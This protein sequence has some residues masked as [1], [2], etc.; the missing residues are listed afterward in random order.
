[1]NSTLVG[2]RA[3]LGSGLLAASVPFRARAQQ[4][5]SVRIGVLNDQNGP[6][7]DSGGPGSVVAARMAVQD[8]GGT[9]LGKKI[10]I[11]FADTRNKPDIASGVAREW[12]D[13]GLDAITDL[14]V[15]PIAAAV[16][17]IAR[18]RNRTV[19]IAAAVATEFTSKTCSPVSSHWVDDTHSMVSATTKAT[20]KGSSQKWFFI[21]VDYTFGRALQAEATGLIEAAGGKVIG[22]D[23]FPLGSTDFSSQVVKAQSSGADVIGLAAVGNDQVNLIKQAGE[24]GLATSGK[25]TLAGFLIYI[26]DIHALGLALSQGLTFGSGF[27]WDQSEA[28]RA[29]GKRYQ[30]E[31]KAMPSKT[32]AAV[33]AS[34]LHFLKSM[35]QAGTRDAIAVNRAMRSLPVENFGRPTTLRTDGRVMYDLSLYRVKAPANS[36]GSWDYYE[37]IGAIPAGEAF[38][39][40]NPDCER[41]A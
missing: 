12:Y 22:S 38:L 28:S 6:Y 18:E 9:V 34:T 31:R 40:I 21:T 41:A 24:F 32:Q 5:D 25:L 13:S 37:E 11:L 33:Y 15:T 27:Y 30:A 19:M 17:Q 3:V 10:E 7:A 23:Y 36:R 35:Q 1:M 4:A 26:T 16:Q 39:P 2:R 29:F 8:F 14:P 20:V